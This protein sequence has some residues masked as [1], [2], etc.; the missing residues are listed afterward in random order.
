MKV[1]TLGVSI[2][3]VAKPPWGHRID[4]KSPGN[5]ISATQRQSNVTAVRTRL[6]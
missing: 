1:L 3:L 6:T 5:K 4:L 2:S